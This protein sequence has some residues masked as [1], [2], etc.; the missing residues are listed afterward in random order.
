MCTTLHQGNAPPPLL[1]FAVRDVPQPRLSSRVACVCVCVSAACQI[2]LA[3]GTS[4]LAM[5]GP[6]LR[7]PLSLLLLLFL[8]L[9]DD[10]DRALFL[11]FRLHVWGR[12]ILEEG[13]KDRR[14]YTSIPCSPGN[15]SRIEP[16]CLLLSLLLLCVLPTTFRSYTGLFLTGA[17]IGGEKSNT[18]SRPFTPPPYFLFVSF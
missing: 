13:G 16:C 1:S 7:P 17:F 2:R 14:F 8:F 5:E 10:V 6:R 18:T 12:T 4:I 15:I 11:F 3:G 9:T